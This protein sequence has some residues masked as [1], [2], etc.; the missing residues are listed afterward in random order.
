MYLQTVSDDM[1]C[2]KELL[3]DIKE[4]EIGILLEILLDYLCDF[5][6]LGLQIITRCR[7]DRMPIVAANP[8]STGLILALS[9]TRYL[10]KRG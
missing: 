9:L 7:L 5:Y 3:G 4:R 2:L 1:R 6:F 10:L 8:V